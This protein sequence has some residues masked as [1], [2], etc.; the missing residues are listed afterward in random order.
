MPCSRDGKEFYY[1]RTDQKT[2]EVSVVAVDVE[3]APALK[4]GSPRVLFT[5]PGPLPGNPGQHITRDGER[6]VFVMPMGK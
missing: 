4:V 2:S 6:F 3:T 5:L 1:L